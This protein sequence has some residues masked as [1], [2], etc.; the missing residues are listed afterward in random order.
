MGFHLQQ[1]HLIQ[2][3]EYV[4]CLIHA[5]PVLFAHAIRFHLQLQHPFPIAFGQDPQQAT[6]ILNLLHQIELSMLYA[7]P[8]PV[9]R[10]VEVGGEVQLLDL[11]YAQGLFAS[12]LTFAVP[13]LYAFGALRLQLPLQ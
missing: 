2:S 11:E 4:Q 7:R 3:L 9:Y 10:V 5:Q 1:L 6:V 12:N 13:S 8:Q